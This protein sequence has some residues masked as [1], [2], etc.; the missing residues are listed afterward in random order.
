M[1]TGGPPLQ[2]GD[3]YPR[4]A[5]YH[6]RSF[7]EL[8]DNRFAA[9][10]LP[11]TPSSVHPRA[12][13]VE[14]ALKDCAKISV[15]EFALFVIDDNGQ[16]KQYTSTSLRPHQQRIFSDRFKTDFRRNLQ[17]AAQ[18]S[19]SVYSQ[20]GSMYD[21]FD[22][23]SDVRTRHSTSGDSSSDARRFRQSRSE[24]TDDESTNGRRKRHRP[25]YVDNDD[26]PVPIPVIKTQ[27]LEIGDDVEVEKFYNVRFKDMQQSSCKI[28]GKAFVKL[29][30][31]KKQTHHPYTK[32]AAKAPPWWPE[33]TGE[34]HV[35]HREPDHL[36]K[37]ER[38]RLLVHILKMVIEPRH[39][40][41][42]A[43]QKLE[44]NVRKLEE[45]TME[46]MSN[47]FNDKEHPENGDKKRYL[48]EIFK[49]AKQQE[50]YKDDQIDGT[51]R[52]PVQFGER[53]AFD[54]SDDDDPDEGIKDEDDEV[55]VLSSTNGISPSEAVIPIPPSMIQPNHIQHENDFS[56][57]RNIPVRHN[58]QP[59]SHMYDQASYDGSY[60]PHNMNVKFHQMSP[61]VQDPIR[62]SFASPNFPS[63]QANA[64]TW[65]NNINP[66]ASPAQYYPS[67]P[68]SLLPAQSMYLPPPNSLQ[69]MHPPPA[70][71]NFDG[72]PNGVR[73]DMEPAQSQMRTRSLGHLQQ[74]PQGFPDFIETNYMQTDQGMKHEQHMSAN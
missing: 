64:Y 51:T 38:I 54:N 62:R 20:D 34:N 12:L 32:G 11:A 39:K 18:N 66:T 74:L 48:K 17:R 72:L 65:Q 57:Q 47:W 45:V 71:H 37:P 58:T 13:P 59:T 31:P 27:Q 10:S 42:P 61:N 23:E 29:I 1:V 5:H 60:N 3:F 19:Y 53:G 36:L 46:A 70:Q 68:H 16:E 21:E 30:E 4:D 50:R 49:V 24:E 69:N 43:V 7:L 56:R 22:T 44:L 14:T 2:R 67:S 26:T 9:A 33:T 55:D 6:E 15:K 28:M 25:Q 63:P 73:Y 8:S 40:Q 41:Q 35:R 52:I